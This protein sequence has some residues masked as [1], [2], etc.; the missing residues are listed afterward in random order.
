VDFILSLLSKHASIVIGAKKPKKQVTDVC[1]Q[2]AKE[3]LRVETEIGREKELSVV[4]AIVHVLIS[5][6][7]CF[8]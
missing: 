3:K 6:P 2:Y 5:S 7:P 1:G 8:C 4:Q